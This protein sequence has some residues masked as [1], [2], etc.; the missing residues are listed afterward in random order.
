MEGLQ[1][2]DE[3]MKKAGDDLNAIYAYLKLDA[4]A[5]RLAAMDHAMAAAIAGK[6]SPRGANAFLNEMEP[7]RAAQVTHGMVA[8]EAA[9]NGKKS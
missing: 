2:H 1:K 9:P 6:L 5:L 4:A 8:P 7:A 3:A